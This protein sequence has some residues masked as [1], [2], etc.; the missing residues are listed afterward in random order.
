MIIASD[1]DRTIIYSNRAIDEL[2]R[3]SELMLKPVES[4]EGTGISFM[5]STSLIA[6]KAIFREYQF[7]PITTR[8]IE[9]YRRIHIFQDELLPRYAIT[10]NGANI[11]LDGEQIKEWSELLSAKMRNETATI[12]EIISFLQKEGY[13]FDGIKRQVENLFIYFILNKPM[14]V[15]DKLALSTLLA[16]FGWNVSL[17]GRKLYFIP[18]VINKGD[19]LEYVCSHSGGSALAGSGDSILDLDFL[20]HC[21]Y[22]FIPNH[23]ELVQDPDIDIPQR[24]CVTKNNGVLA[25][26]EILNQYLL[27]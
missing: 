11:L 22:G 27:L 24:M 18:K 9:Q 8:T 12:D 13:F 4:R 20:K 23:S 10:S 7:V 19:A 14:P 3:P 17:Q 25:G 21:R 2:G 5:T 6:L 26:E 15:G 16:R 1:L